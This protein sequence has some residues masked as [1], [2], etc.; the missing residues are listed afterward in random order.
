MSYDIMIICSDTPHGE[1]EDMLDVAKLIAAVEGF[2]AFAMHGISWEEQNWTDI[3]EFAGLYMI[4]NNHAPGRLP[5]GEFDYRAGEAECCSMHMA[6]GRFD[7]DQCYE[8]A[9][10]LA[11]KTGARAWDLQTGEEVVLD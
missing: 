1:V 10:Y 11:K 7:L 5:S 3:P 6:G 4:L 2:P 9:A 8:L